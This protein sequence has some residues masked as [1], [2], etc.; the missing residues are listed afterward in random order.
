MEGL[1]DSLIHKFFGRGSCDFSAE[2]AVP[3]PGIVFLNA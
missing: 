3:Y 1:A 2:F